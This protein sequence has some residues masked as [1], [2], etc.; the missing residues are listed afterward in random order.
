MGDGENDVEIEPIDYL[1]GVLERGKGKE[2]FYPFVAHSF[3]EEGRM[4][5]EFLQWIAKKDDFILYHWHNYESTHFKKLAMRHG[6]SPGLWV[7]IESSLLDL[8]PIARRSIM[9]PTYGYSL[10][11][12]A[13][14]CGFKWRQKDVSATESIAMYIAYTQTKDSSI[15]DKILKYN[16]DDVIATRAV[17]DWMSSIKKK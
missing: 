1:I 2:K 16:E 3:E 17:K 14:Y 8:L 15:L 10:K 13:P 6:C 9:F 7:K 5:K 4:W 11:K 12:V